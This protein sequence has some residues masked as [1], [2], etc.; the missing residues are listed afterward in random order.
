MKEKL[1]ALLIAQFSGV[2]KDGLAHLAGALAL[3]VT[4]EEEAQALVGKLTKDQ[5][6][7]FIKDFRAGVDKEVTE[8]NSTFKA[9][10]EKKYDLVEK[11]NPNP[12]PNKKTDPNKPDDL[13]AKLEAMLEAKL[14]PVQKELEGYRSGRIAE[15]RLQRLTDKLSACKNEAFKTKALKDFSYMRFESDE[16]FDEYL[17]ETENNVTSFNQSI[18]DADLSKQGYPFMGNKD[19][20]GEDAFINSMKEINKTEN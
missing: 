13:D 14:A 11:G 19:V 20:S 1:L 15:T 12:D 8:S 16:H 18:T 9:N 2:R 6:D 3:N 10:L 17:T 5:V 7:T 4:T